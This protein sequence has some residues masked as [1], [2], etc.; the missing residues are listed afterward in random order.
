MAHTLGKPIEISSSCWKVL[1][2][3]DL[4]WVQVPKDSNPKERDTVGLVLDG[5]PVGVARILDVVYQGPRTTDGHFGCLIRL[6]DVE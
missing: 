5:K 2:I 6:K 4:V 1:F 3:G